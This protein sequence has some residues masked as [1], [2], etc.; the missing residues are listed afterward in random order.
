MQT[1]AQ[2]SDIA[3]MNLERKRF[4]AEQWKAYDF[5][6]SHTGKIEIS[7][8]GNLQ[9]VYFP[10]RP[11]CH[12]LSDESKKKLM[13]SVNRESQSNKVEGLMAAAPDLI[14]EMIYNEGLSRS[15]FAITPERMA[16]LKD[17]STLLAVFMNL[18]LIV[19][20]ERTDHYREVYVPQYASDMI[21]YGGIV[22]GISAG[23]L[24]IFYAMARG[25]LI[26]KARW[27]DFVKENAKSLKPFENEDRLDITEMSIEMT[28]TILMTK[29]PEAS[30]FNL[31]DK[32]VF[33]NLYTR[34]EYQMFN[35]YFFI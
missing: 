17:F 2:N 5:V 33:G 28:H 15:S 9:A 29:G 11:A 26:T 6:R 22:Q 27:R 18:V 12:Y 13:L 10:I 4:N 23:I 1:L 8:H 30:E 7:V 3:K 24:I 21:A 31:D 35:I 14:D 25:G 16:A 34:F 20:T 32:I 19:F